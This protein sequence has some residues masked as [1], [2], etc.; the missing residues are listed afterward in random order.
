MDGN[1][2]PW[3]DYA[4]GNHP[5]QFIRAWR[6]VHHMFDLAGASNVKWVWSPAF[7]STATFPG[8]AYV[9]VMAT[10]CQNG[11]KRLFARGWQSFP[12]GCGKLI[13]RLHTLAPHGPIQLAE[14]ASSEAGG[15][16]A[17]WIEGMFAYLAHHHEV[18]SVVWFN[19]VKKTDWRIESSRAARRAFAAG[20]RSTG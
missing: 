9:D 19:L 7:A 8:T 18:T 5:G 20:A 16:K 12:K 15:S 2:Y 11:G 6:H 4:N 1:W 3:S 17:R 13:Q 10:T 14:A